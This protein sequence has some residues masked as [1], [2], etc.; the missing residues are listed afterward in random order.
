MLYDLAP[1]AASEELDVVLL[2]PLE[3][4]A[5]GDR[6]HDTQEPRKSIRKSTVEIED[7]EPVWHD[8]VRSM[9]RA[10]AT[11]Q[12]ASGQNGACG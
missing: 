2:D 8:A 11:L 9:V 10:E 7:D 4:K 1:A 5:I 6:V 3:S 12:G